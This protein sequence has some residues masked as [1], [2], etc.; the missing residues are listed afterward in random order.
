VRVLAFATVAVLVAGLLFGL[1]P[2][3]MASR[4]NVAGTLR[5]GGRGA[6]AGRSR[7]RLQRGLVALE[8]AL[9]CA[10]LVG[11]GLL[12]RSLSALQGVDTGVQAAGLLVVPVVPPTFAYDS[13]SQ[14]S[15]FHDTVEER[16]AAL[17][18]VLAVGAIDI[19]P[20]SGSF[21][22][23]SFTIEGRPEPDA[24]ARWSAETRMTT[25][26]ALAALGI[27]VVRG[28]GFDAR[29]HEASA[30]VA[31]INEALADRWWPGENPVGARIRIQGDWREVV[32]VVRDVREF[33]PDRAPEP[34]VYLP[35]Q[36]VGSIGRAWLLVRTQGDPLAV[37]GTVRSIVHEVEPRAAFGTP[38]TMDAVVD[39]TLAAPRFRTLLL[40]V[41]AAVAL[42]LAVVG[43]YGVVSRTAAQRRHEVGIRMS[44]GAG[45]RDVVSL[46]LGDGLRPVALGVVL[47]LAGGF[48]L[49]RALAG[50]LFGIAPLDPLT[51]L[52]AP[53]ALA[54][55]AAA[56]CLLP[57][58]RASR[59][60]PASVLRGD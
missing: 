35:H 44:L 26:G 1:A 47:G 55:T 19:L 21:N 10:L 14:I 20:M 27:E 2:V 42:L 43:I 31:L 4:A 8:V 13:V 49:S 59:T 50:L 3:L 52:A 17:S 22:G 16:I 12:I 53:A 25:R 51:F 46:M 24:G 45:R 28:R 60:E 34:G 56:A 30:N 48:A 15:R 11:A 23:N 36:Q 29:D 57:A 39:R 58:R 9:S 33:T 18:G 5:E 41:F 32:G 7:R 37:V 54:I 6:T 38:R 40:A